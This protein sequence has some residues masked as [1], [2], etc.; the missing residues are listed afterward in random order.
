MINAVQYT[1]K[2][3][4]SNLA[5]L[6][7]WACFCVDSILSLFF[8]L[9]VSLNGER[10]GDGRGEDM[11]GNVGGGIIEENSLVRLIQNK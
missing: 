3:S 6:Q 2:L 4:A 1:M 7:I 11:G 9:F 10:G 8:G 5:M